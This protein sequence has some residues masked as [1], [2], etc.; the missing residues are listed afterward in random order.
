MTDI[1]ASCP[2]CGGNDF[3]VRRWRQTRKFVACLHCHAAGPDG[4]NDE[5]AIRL[6]VERSAPKPKVTQEALI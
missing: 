1:D 4:R 5:E 2:F 3:Q 6:F